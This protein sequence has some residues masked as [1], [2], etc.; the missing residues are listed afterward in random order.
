MTHRSRSMWCAPVMKIS[1]LPA[2]ST[3]DFHHSKVSGVTAP[4]ALYVIP[5]ALVITN[6]AR[7][8]TL[9]MGVRLPTMYAS[10]DYVE[11]GGL[12]SY[13]AN[14]PDLWR[15]AADLV[16]KILRGAKPAEIPVEQ[17]T[18]FDLVTNLTTAKALGLDIPQT[19]LARA[20]EITQ[21]LLR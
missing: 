14:Y 1:S 13:G 12:M 3:C 9:A 19:L 20:D 7:I 15:H 10:R 17:P 11:A 6:R 16:D 4:A 5:D 8:H 18:K 2:R 21:V